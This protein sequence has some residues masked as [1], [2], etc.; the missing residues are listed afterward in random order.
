M[1]EQEQQAQEASIRRGLTGREDLIRQIAL[2]ELGRSGRREYEEYATDIARKVGQALRHL[3]ESPK[4][5]EGGNKAMEIEHEQYT[6]IDY[7]LRFVPID[8]KSVSEGLTPEGIASYAFTGARAEFK[9]QPKPRREIFEAV[10]SER[11]QV[12]GDQRASEAF[13]VGQDCQCADT[14][15]EAEVREA[16]DAAREVKTGLAGMIEFVA[17]GYQKF[18]YTLFEDY[19]NR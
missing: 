16:F 11:I 8:E 19:L 14:Y 6:P 18:K 5:S 17:T 4:P 15:T 10:L 3:E 7:G 12:Y 13:D 9:D 1:S 2:M